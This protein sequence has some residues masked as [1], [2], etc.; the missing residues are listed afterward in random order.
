[1]GDTKLAS[2]EKTLQEG[3]WS[4]GGGAG[5]VGCLG[6]GR[7]LGTGIL[8]GRGHLPSCLPSGHLGPPCHLLPFL[9]ASLANPILLG[10]EHRLQPSG[11]Q[12]QPSIDSL[13]QSGVSG[14]KQFPVFICLPDYKAMPQGRE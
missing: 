1:M 7:H 12:V 2:K 13:F 11:P 10:S 9:E 4:L 3:Y 5:Q 8:S 6:K 14:V